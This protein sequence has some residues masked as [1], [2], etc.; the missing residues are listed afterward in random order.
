MGKRAGLTYRFEKRAAPYVTALE[1]AGFEVVRITPESP[2]GVEGIDAL[3]F[4]GGTDVEAARF[5]QLADA[6]SDEPD[7]DRDEL[8]AS[9]LRDALAADTPMLCI[10]RGMQM[11]NVVLGG[12]DRK[13]GRHGDVHQQL[14]S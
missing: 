1:R 14:A 7:I 10:C 13:A 2:R 12:D 5:G 9:L 8:E 4:S 3:V 6:H 11:L